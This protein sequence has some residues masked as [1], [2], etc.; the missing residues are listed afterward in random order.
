MGPDQPLT[1]EPGS[2]SCGRFETTLDSGHRR[3]SFGF[4]GTSTNLCL[5]LAA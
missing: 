2:G 1:G 5:D 3:T 4:V